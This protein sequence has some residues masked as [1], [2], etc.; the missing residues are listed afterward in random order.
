[1]VEF[2]AAVIT[3]PGFEDIAATEVEELIGVKAAADAAGIVSF[4]AK[5]L[6]DL[7]K[8]CYL[9]QSASSVVLLLS[10]FAVSETAAST[11]E[12]LKKS[13]KS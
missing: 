7:C 6:I 2:E 9:S 11:A 1:M 13:L 10:E 4:Q 8:L 12:N 5:Q 3:Y